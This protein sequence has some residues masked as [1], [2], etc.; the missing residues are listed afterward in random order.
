M[1][2]T[3]R[4]YREGVVTTEEYALLLVQA[5]ATAAFADLQVGI[6]RN[7]AARLKAGGAAADCIVRLDAATDQLE[8]AVRETGRALR[9]G[10]PP[11]P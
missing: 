1:A 11:P 9:S 6:L 8:A 2:L 4:A 5:R 3:G 10:L 7:L